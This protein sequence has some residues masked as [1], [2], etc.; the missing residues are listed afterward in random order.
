[1]TLHAAQTSAQVGLGSGLISPLF[2][3]PSL[4][5]GQTPVFNLKPLCSIMLDESYRCIPSP[6]PSN[7]E[8]TI[9][10]LRLAQMANCDGDKPG[11]PEGTVSQHQA[12]KPD[13][14]RFGT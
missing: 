11:P 5:A 13:K 12:T 10:L 9:E 2:K 8:L 6:S 7:G 1:V 4:T 3:L 14:F